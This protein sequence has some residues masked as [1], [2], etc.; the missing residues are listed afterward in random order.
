MTN[1]FF[2]EHTRDF[3]KIIVLVLNFGGVSALQ[4]CKLVIFMAPIRLDAIELPHPVVS[5]GAHSCLAAQVLGKNL[6]DIFFK[7]HTRQKNGT[8][9]SCANFLDKQ[10]SQD[11][12]LDHI[13]TEKR[14]I[15]RLEKFPRC[16]LWISASQA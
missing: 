10:L 9:R 15:T 4:H 1:N 3:T 14:G 7:S 16:I 6:E 5:V 8:R 2:L 13:D 12:S 11:S